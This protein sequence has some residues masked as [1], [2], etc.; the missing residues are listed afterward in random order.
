MFNKSKYQP[1]KNIQNRLS[2]F[3]RS[4]SRSLLF[5]F[6]FISCQNNININNDGMKLIKGGTFEMGGDNDQ[7][8]PD[9][10]PKHSV[11][12]SD[13]WIDETEV[14]NAQFKAFVK[15][16]NYIT[17]AEK[18]FEYQDENGTTIQQK[19]GSLVFQKLD[20]NQDATISN[21][22][23]F[24]EGANWKHPQGPNSTIEGKDNYPVVQ[25]SWYD[26]IAYCKWS[27]KRLPTEAEREYAAR[28][29][30]KNNIY[31]FGN[32]NHQVSKKLNSWNGEFPYENTMLDSFE[33]TSPV[34][35]YEANNYG[36]YDM[37]GNV[38]EWCNDNYSAKYYDICKK[39]R[40][41]NNPIGDKGNNTNE[42][43]IRG[44]SFLCN[45][46]YCSGFRVAARMKT[47]A[48]TSLEHTGF[49]CVRNS[50]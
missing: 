25:V 32:D 9:E 29:G 10:F 34:K 48:E 1:T 15:A 21:W 23:H 44:G 14:T 3:L 6:I 47:S 24:I 16:T 43:V 8:R 37:A 42:K 26:A 2:I 17:T 5:S 12:V 46:S 11:T 27:K 49:R 45:D 7:A 39:N 50:K 19:A 41:L 33:R 30:L 38:W 31:T 20:R 35:F 40:I 18:D 4:L 13:F 28:A 36:L 22:W